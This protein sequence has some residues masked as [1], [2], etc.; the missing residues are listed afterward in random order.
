MT[1]IRR[2]SRAQWEGTVE[3]GSGTIGIGQ[4][5]TSLP[6]SLKTR[7]GD[8]AATNP[9]ELLGSA[10]AGC[11]SMSLAN[12][13]GSAGADFTVVHTSATVHLVQSD[14]GF[15]IP[16]VDLETSVEGCDLPHERVEEIARTAEEHC[17]VAR[18]FDADINLS[19]ARS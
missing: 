14:T 9:E 6:F 2:T 5:D 11:Y 8:Q 15:S 1:T 18:L 19:V 17:P 16:T 12:E 3:T 13:L 10:L 4:S 7:V